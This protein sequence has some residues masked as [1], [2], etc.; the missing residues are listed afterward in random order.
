MFDV[1]I[2]ALQSNSSNTYIESK[3]I[4]VLNVLFSVICWI[5]PVYYFTCKMQ[6]DKIIF[7]GNFKL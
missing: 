1:L 5:V 2:Y 3:A 4:P 7:K 6:N